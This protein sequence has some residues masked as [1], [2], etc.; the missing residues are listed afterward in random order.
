M[1]PVVRNILAVVVGFVVGSIVNSGLINIGPYIVPLPDGADVSTMENLRESMRLFTAANFLFPFLA[2]AVGTL[3]GAF[4][5][6]KLAVSHRMQFAIGIGVAFLIGGVVAAYLISAP[7]WFTVLDLVLA[8]L[9]MGIM[10]GILAGA[11]WTPK[12]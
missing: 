1:H 10:G 7:V 8:Y 3:V 5:A 9:P 12:T 2:H 11:K 6:A 4:L